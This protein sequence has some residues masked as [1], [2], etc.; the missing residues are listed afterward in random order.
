MLSTD[1]LIGPL[2][3]VRCFLRNTKH[4]LINPQRGAKISFWH[5]ALMTANDV[6]LGVA[7]HSRFKIGSDPASRSETEERPTGLT[8][9]L[10]ERFLA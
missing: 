7:L 2:T 8:A 5:P 3:S 1:K 9:S 6:A 4:S 10:P